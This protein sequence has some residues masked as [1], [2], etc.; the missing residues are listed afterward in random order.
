MVENRVVGMKSRGIYE[1]PGGAIL[2]KAHE[3]LEQ[4]CLDAKTKSTKQQLALQYA[5][6]VYG[7]LWFTP[8]REALDAFMTET[9]KNVTGTVTLTL[10]K[11]N[12]IPAG[13]TSP[14]SLYSEALASFTT[15]ELYDH[16]DAQ[17]FITLY[18]LP[19]KVR[20]LVMQQAENGK[21]K[22]PAGV[23]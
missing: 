11:G 12:I 17:G 15:G 14:Y 21:C 2:Y 19:S 23:S 18:G 8:L 4:L 9:Q 7:G 20:A 10:Y 1:N 3:L 22:T 5:E 13:M 16:A 6:L